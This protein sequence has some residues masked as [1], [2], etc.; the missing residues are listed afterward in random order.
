VLRTALA[1]GLGLTALWTTGA[2]ARFAGPELAP[3]VVEAHEIPAPGDEPRLA[4]NGRMY[5]V[6]LRPGEGGHGTI[7][8]T[9]TGGVLAL[10]WRCSRFHDN[11]QR[12]IGWR[13]TLLFD[14]ERGW[15]RCSVC[16]TLFTRAGMKVFG[17]AGYALAWFAL[18]QRPDG[19]LLVAPGGP[20]SGFSWDAQPE[21]PAVD[22]WQHPLV[23]R[24]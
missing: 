8:G 20:T 10:S 11:R 21:H 24:A 7:A 19:S 2:L 12:P 14:G 13:S 4:T 16:C 22:G 17:P 3:L 1:G 23:L 15:F 18:H 6:N 9:R 5:L